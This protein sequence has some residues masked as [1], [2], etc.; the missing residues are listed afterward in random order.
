MSGYHV[1]GLGTPLQADC[2]VTLTMPMLRRTRVR[3]PLMKKSH[4]NEWLDYD[5][6]PGYTPTG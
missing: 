5:P 1:P 6:G 2:D 4:S 3:I